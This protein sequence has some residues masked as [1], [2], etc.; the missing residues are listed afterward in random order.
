MY[1]FP[2]EYHAEVGAAGFGEEPIGTGPWRFAEWNKGVDLKV[3]PNPD[4]W[5]EQ[6]SIGEIQF[7]WAP[8]ASSRV[9]LLE[10][11]E[12]HIAQNVPP[13]LIGRVQNSGNARVETAKSI[14]K[15]FLRTNIDDGPT[16][17][18]RVRQALNHAI[19]VDLIMEALFRGRAYGRDT[20]FILEGME[21]YEDGRLSPFEYNPEKAKELLAEAGYPDGFETTFWHTIGRYMLDKETAEAIAGQLAEVGIDVT[22][23]GMEPGAYFSKVSSERLPG[24]HFAASAPL[25]MTPLY[26]PMIEFQL[27]MPYGYGGNEETDTYTQAA[28]AELDPEQRV[29]TL[30]EFEDYVFTEHVPWVWLWHYQDIYGVSN[31][32]NW[33]ARP[34]EFMTFEETTFR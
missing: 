21:G 6:P 18:V 16:A 1:V 22:L 34:D 12:V 13:A 17:D 20:G 8:E 14:R 24:I 3:E 9:A 30:Q 25:F 27:D 29:K 11:G 23:E 28:M 7:R 10:T 33:T 31:D 26:H 5:G 2:P 15:A 32:V 4:Y 19:D